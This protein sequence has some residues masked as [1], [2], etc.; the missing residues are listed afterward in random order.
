MSKVEKIVHD[1]YIKKVSCFIVD[2]VESHVEGGS[3]ADGF[4]RDG[5][6]AVP[7]DGFHR[8]GLSQTNGGSPD[9]PRCTEKRC[10]FLD[11]IYH[12]CRSIMYYS[13]HEG[14]NV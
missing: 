6:T 10:Q 2:L 3:R 4:F 13:V 7:R 8:F 5:E 12:A 11:D 1:L 9:C 14:L